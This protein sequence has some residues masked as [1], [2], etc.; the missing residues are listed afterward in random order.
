MSTN[1]HCAMATQNGAAT[2]T[3]NQSLVMGHTAQG[4]EIR[5]TLLRLTRYFAVCEI[6][7]PGLVLRTSEALDQFKVVFQDRTIYSGRAVIHNLV[8]AG[9]MIVCELK[10]DENSWMDLE[11]KPGP[12]HNGLLSDEYKNFIGEW[13]QRYNVLPEFKVAIADMQSFLFDLRLWLDQVELNVRSQPSGSREEFERQV[14]QSLREPV[15]PSLQLLFERFENVAAKIEKEHQPS[16][17]IYAKRQLHPVVLCAPFMYRTFQKP[18]GYAGDYEMV[19]MMAQDSFQGGSMFAKV[20]NTFFL[21]TPPVIA[22]RNRIARLTQLLDEETSRVERQGRTARVL[23]LGCGPALEVQNF[24][25][26]SRFSQ[27][28]EITLLDFNDETVAHTEHVLRQIKRRGNQNTS[29]RVLKKSVTQFLKENSR[30]V[31]QA[32]A[33]GYDFVYCA[34]LFDYMTN[35]VCEKLL[36]LFYDLAAPDGLV[37]ITNVDSHNPS[38]G[39]ME[40]VVDWHLLYRDSREMTT[41][42]PQQIPQ[43]ALRIVAESSGVNNFVEIRKPNHG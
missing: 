40:Y 21:S 22:H 17:A 2:G 1:F 10:L 16:H 8:D 6:Y 33:G 42:I 24:L 36:S 41:L 35:P 25:Q 15:L 26:Q 43:D 20:L 23:N 28:A 29:I 27:R 11:F 39:W 31:S 4:I 5:A 32:G 7:N 18:L 38:R 34:G 3:I 30:T 14:L 19:N 9:V 12:A 13:Q 37:A